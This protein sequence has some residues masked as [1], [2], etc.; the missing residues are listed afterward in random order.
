MSKGK[1]GHGSGSLKTPPF[2]EQGETEASCDPGTTS[3]YRFRGPLRHFSEVLALGGK[4][5]RL[6][7]KAAKATGQLEADTGRGRD[8]CMETVAKEPSQS[9]HPKGQQCKQENQSADRV[10]HK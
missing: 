3:L 7:V 2:R 8:G 1:L 9:Q 4:S 10:R 6:S 5:L